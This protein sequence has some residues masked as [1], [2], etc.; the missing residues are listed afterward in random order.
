M[1]D[2]AEKWIRHTNKELRSLNKGVTA[3]LVGAPVSHWERSLQGGLTGDLGCLG[4]GHPGGP[5]EDLGW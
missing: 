1:P 5:S 3:I 2:I 4:T